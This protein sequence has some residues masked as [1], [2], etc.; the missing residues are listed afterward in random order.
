MFQ[1]D[2]K[3]TLAADGSVGIL[4]TSVLSDDE[5]DEKQIAACVYG[6]QQVLNRT[7]AAALS[8]DVAKAGAP[9]TVPENLSAD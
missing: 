8:M 4:E 6:T 1:A 9:D 7:V 3:L 2:T 5:V